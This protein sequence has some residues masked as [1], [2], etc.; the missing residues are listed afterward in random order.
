MNPKRRSLGDDWVIELCLTHESARKFKIAQQ[1]TRTRF[2]FVLDA[3]HGSGKT[4]SGRILYMESP[5][6]RGS[7]MI[8]ITRGLSLGEAYDFCRTFAQEDIAALIKMFRGDLES[9]EEYNERIEKEARLR[10]EA[11]QSKRD[12]IRE[13]MKGGNLIVR[14]GILR[15]QS[16]ISKAYEAAQAQIRD[17]KLMDQMMLRELRKQVREILE[18][19]PEDMGVMIEAVIEV[20]GKDGKILLDRALDIEVR[21]MQKK[22]ETMQKKLAAKGKK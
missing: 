20:M 1:L 11:D 9:Q 4:L 6:I 18:G 16:P 3:P 21:A 13:E 7:K 8:E 5:E 22:V 14:N 19:D 12:I 10:E 17:Q 15:W 2:H